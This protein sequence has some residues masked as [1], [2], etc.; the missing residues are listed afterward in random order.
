MRFEDVAWRDDFD[1][2]WA[3][4]S[5]LHI[6]PGSFSYTASR[7]ARALKPG[8]VWYMSFKLGEGERVAD[9]RL[10]VDQSEATLRRA[11]LLLPIEATELWVSPDLRPGRQTDHWLNAVVVRRQQGFETEQQ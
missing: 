3:C 2:I 1:G 7:L 9:G 6:P 10:F 11:L 5:L 8:G 4:A